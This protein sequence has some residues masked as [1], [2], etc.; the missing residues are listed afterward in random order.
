MNRRRPATHMWQFG[1]AWL[2][3]GGGQLW[4]DSTADAADLKV[5]FDVGYLVACRDVS[6]PEFA[7]SHP[8]EK[9][10]EARF[11][12][13]AFFHQGSDND[14]VEF[15]YEIES[16]L[17]TLYVVDFE[18]KT[19][20]ISSIVGPMNI[21][22]V[23]ESNRNLGL[24]IAGKYDYFVSTNA[25][26]SAG[27]GSK[28]GEKVR[29]DKL[30]NLDLLAASGTT[31][32]GHGVYFKLRPSSQTSLEGAKELVCIFRVPQN[33]RG[34]L[35]RLKCQAVEHRGGLVPNLSSPKHSAMFQVGL[36]LQGDKIAA[37]V[38]NQ[39]LQQEQALRSTLQE[40]F[41]E[42]QS[43]RFHSSIPGVA[44]LRA[45]VDPA[46]LTELQAHLLGRGQEAVDDERLPHSVRIALR[47]YRAAWISARQLC[48]DQ[49]MLAR[50][51]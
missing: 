12:I 28:D 47:N 30:P 21:E 39:R 6:P 16:P 26:A 17:R 2:V 9:L 19:E 31:Q 41:R 38:M 45:M 35:V 42:L 8:G 46:S 32:R 5:S 48:G 13:S 44:A 20:M 22:R 11:Q 24:G 15:I 43:T 29:Y 1:L 3:I 7:H 40:H 10:V 25:N 49:A 33:W 36:Y 37:A 51:E 4:M 14:L 23:Q 50:F 34:D 18:P 27:I